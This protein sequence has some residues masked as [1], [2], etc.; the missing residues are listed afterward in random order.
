MFEWNYF[1]SFF[2]NIPL[3]THGRR[4]SKKSTRE[5]KGFSQGKSIREKLVQVNIYALHAAFAKMCCS[6]KMSIYISYHSGRRYKERLDISMK[7]KRS[8]YL[9][10]DCYVFQIFR[11]RV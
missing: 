7:T 9:R 5:G 8:L 4:L 6:T 3:P 2:R 1:P 10:P 11:A